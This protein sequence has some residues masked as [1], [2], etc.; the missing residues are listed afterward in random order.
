MRANGWT[1]LPERFW[2]RVEKTDGC[3]LWTGPRRR[4]GYGRIKLAGKDTTAHRVAWIMLFGPIP[5]GVEVCH[6]CD[7]K[8]CVRPDHLYLGTHALN[9]RD[10]SDHGL[11]AHKGQGRHGNHARGERHGTKTHPESVARGAA[12]YKAKLTEAQA[13]EIKRRRLA[14]EPLAVLA[15]EFGVTMALVS[16]IARGRVWSHL[17]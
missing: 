3:W 4:D 14:G 6:R 7:V 11:F 15:Q 1:P 2:P 8:L 5:S 17:D 16:G 12:H 9:M 13:I 10:A